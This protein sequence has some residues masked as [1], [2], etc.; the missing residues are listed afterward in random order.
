M[1]DLLGRGGM[2]TVFFA[3]NGTYTQHQLARIY[4]GGRS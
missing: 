2:A 1:T 3:L 4:I